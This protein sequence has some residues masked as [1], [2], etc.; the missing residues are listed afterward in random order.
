MHFDSTG[1]NLTA[2]QDLSAT[3]DERKSTVVIT[4]LHTSRHKNVTPSR[5]E[6]SIRNSAGRASDAGIL[7][8]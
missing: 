3:Y 6:Q 4:A 5:V 7:W 2:R 1:C 8:W